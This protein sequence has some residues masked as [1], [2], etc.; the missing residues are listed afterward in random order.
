MKIKYFAP[1]TDEVEVALENLLAQS[2]DG[3]LEDM[4][5]DIIFDNSII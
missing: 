3:T 2:S 5:G 1:L 4:P